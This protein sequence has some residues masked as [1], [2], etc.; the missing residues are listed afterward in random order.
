MSIRGV[1]SVT[2]RILIRQLREVHRFLGRPI[3][4]IWDDLSSHRSRRMYAFAALSHWL[5]LVH[6]PPYVPDLNLVEGGWA[7]IKNGPLANLGARTLDEFLTTARCGLRHIQHHP[8]LVTGFLAATRL[9]RDPQP[10]T[11]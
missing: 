1:G 7:H 6:L 11:P 9:D 3:V 4:L 2:D 10:S 5:T 8:A